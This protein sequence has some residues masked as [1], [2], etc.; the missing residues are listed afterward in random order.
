MKKLFF[1]SLPNKSNTLCTENAKRRGEVTLAKII[2]FRNRLHK[3]APRPENLDEVLKIVSR[4]TFFKH[5]QSSKKKKTLSSGVL[6]LH[7]R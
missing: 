7:K 6:I 1:T 3:N 4:R 2:V 5:S